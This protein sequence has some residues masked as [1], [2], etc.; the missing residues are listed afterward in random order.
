MHSINKYITDM[1]RFYIKKK[2]EINYFLFT[3]DF[4]FFFRLLHDKINNKVPEHKI[5]MTNKNTKPYLEIKRNRNVEYIH[6][7]FEIN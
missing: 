5:N 3:D 7:C 6:H 1:N 4:S 2:H